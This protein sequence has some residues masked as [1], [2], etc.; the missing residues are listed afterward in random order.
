M[1]QETSVAPSRSSLSAP[2]KAWWPSRTVKPDTTSPS[3]SAPGCF[4]YVVVA[5]TD[6]LPSPA[7]AVTIL[8]TDP[9]T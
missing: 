5:D 1:L 7:I 6:P 3:A 8:N 4:G 9:G 2:V